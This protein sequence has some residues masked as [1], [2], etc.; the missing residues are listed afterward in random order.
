MKLLILGAGGRTGKILVEQALAAGHIVTAFVH[1]ETDMNMFGSDV[2]VISGDA[3]NASDL[4]KALK[5]QKAVISTL[6]SSKPGDRIITSTTAALI[7]GADNEGVK[8]IL[9]MS[10]FLATENFQPPLVVK[11]ALKLMHSI[12]KDINSGE[13]LLRL[14]DTDYTIVHATRLTNSPLVPNYRVIKEGQKLGTKDKISRADVAYFLLKA[15]SEKKYIRTSVII[16][17]N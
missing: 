2:T 14:S 11:V 9:L 7:K 13:E 12:V 4:E 8:R 5:G 15:L 1:S 10:S 17:E 6:G 3:R 16:T